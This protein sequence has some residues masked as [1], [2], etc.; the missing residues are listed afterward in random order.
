MRQNQ[1]N[2]RSRARGNGKR[3]NIRSQ[4]FESNGPGVKVRGT[5]QQVLDKYLA[6]ARDASSS[7][8][9]IAAEA[10]YQHAEHYFR[11]LTAADEARNNQQQRRPQNDRTPA[12][13]APETDDELGAEDADAQAGE[14]EAASEGDGEERPQRDTRRGRGRRGSQNR[15]RRDSRSDGDPSDAATT[16]ASE[17][18]DASDE[19]DA[20]SGEAE[21]ELTGQQ[22]NTATADQDD[23]PEAAS[24]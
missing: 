8:D 21:V 5:A 6:L 3:G 1:N 10:F 24:A 11:L 12:D 19:A 20:A 4:N 13:D 23:L 17:S 15:Q 7:G 14:Q 18:I 9:R 22:A 16:Q 2:R